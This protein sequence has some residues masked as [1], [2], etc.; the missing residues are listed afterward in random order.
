MK[1]NRRLA[2]AE[3]RVA[4]IQRELEATKSFGPNMDN[5]YE[6][7]ATKAVG[8]DEMLNLRI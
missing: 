4:R 6:K 3:A 5:E 2:Q 7:M 1:K 8:G